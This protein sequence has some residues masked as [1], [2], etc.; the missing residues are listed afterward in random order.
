M[1]Q[2][3]NLNPSAHV[4]PDIAADSS[5]QH[6]GMLDQ[7]GMSEID[8]PILIEAGNAAA[9]QLM[10]KVKTFVNL[11]DT[12]SRGIHM[13]R[14]YIALEQH[15]Q[16]EPLSP[17]VLHTILQHFLDSHQ[18]LSDSAYLRLD[19]Q[20]PMKRNA[21]KSQKTG[22]RQYPLHIQAQLTPDGFAVEVGVTVQYSSTCPCSAALARQLIQQKFNHDFA[23]DSVL[24]KQTVFDWLGK[25]ESICATPHS[26]RSTAEVKV[27]LQQNVTEFDFVRLI[28]CLEDALQ[29]P[30][31]TAVKREDEQEF[32]RLNGQNLMFCEDAGRRIA[33][34]L[35]KQDAVADFYAL[36]SHF[37]S[38]HPHDA[39]SAVCK[40]IPNGY[41]VSI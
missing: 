15:L 21:L 8:T 6:E 16:D 10:A 22:W 2:M 27:R 17:A 7:V 12:S 26:Q 4:M 19:F 25:E 28:D 32:A 29:T 40:G 20:L 13:S 35:N 23:N 34:A 37:E 38:L 24:E 3:L 33:A 5:V 18:G 30:V 9:F 39:V 41:Q 11:T 14:L 36:I 1:N 31:Q